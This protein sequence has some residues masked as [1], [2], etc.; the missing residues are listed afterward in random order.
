MTK[1]IIPTG[2]K[3]SNGL[4]VKAR[5]AEPSPPPIIDYDL[6]IDDLRLKGLLAIQRMMKY[7]LEQSVRGLPDRD[8]VM[9]LKDCMM[10]LKDLKKDEDDTL[11]SLSIEQLERLRNENE[12]RN[13]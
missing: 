9:T 8:S 3:D 5:E 1:K 4:Y 2:I 13:S 10:M 6:S 12:S 7:I 11:S